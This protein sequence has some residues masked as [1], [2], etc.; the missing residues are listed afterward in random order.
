MIR[1]DSRCPERLGVEHMAQQNDLKQV[2]LV[3]IARRCAQ[4]TTL[5]F[6]KKRHN[7]R[8]CFEMFRRAIV[9]R[10][11]DAWG[12]VYTQYRPLVIGW[13]RRHSS[14]PASGEEVQY[15]VNRAFEKMWV[16]LPPER[17]QRFPDL[18]SLLRYLQ[19]CAH[20]AIIDDS[21]RAQLQ[22]VDL[23]P[24]GHSGQAATD[25]APGGEQEWDRFRREELWQQVTA[26]LNDDR[27]RIIVY[28]SFVLALKPRELYAQFEESFRDVKEVY[29]IKENV[30]ARLGRDT[31]LQKILRG[32]A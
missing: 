23:E 29:R 28:G 13:I 12:L 24:E 14:F 4:E 7:P 10:D 2:P 1:Q 16:A 25:G 19:M 21:R 30:L 18:K 11:Q 8:F 3:G 27:E 32:D 15:F 22:L 20:S 5:F 6:Q 9:E 17:F 31:E 26:R